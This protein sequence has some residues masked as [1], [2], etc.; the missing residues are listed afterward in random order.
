MILFFSTNKICLHSDN[1]FL[2]FFFSVLW[3]LTDSLVMACAVLELVPGTCYYASLILVYLVVCLPL[4]YFH[5]SLLICVAIGIRRRR[6]LYLTIGLIALIEIILYIAVFLFPINRPSNKF[7]RVTTFLCY[8]FH[9]LKIIVDPFRSKNR[10]QVYL[11]CK[12]QLDK[13]GY[14]FCSSECAICHEEYQREDKCA[15]LQECRHTFHHLCLHKWLATK[16]TCPLCRRKY[17]G[18][19]AD[20][21]NFRR[22]ET[23]ATLFFWFDRL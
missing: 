12:Y 23:A 15:M 7:N 10:P 4:S 5:E 19:Y 2:F 20:I 3:D 9:R 8:L 18:L 1:F 14:G 6:S 22:L 11:T 17:H 21:D 13:L 16:T